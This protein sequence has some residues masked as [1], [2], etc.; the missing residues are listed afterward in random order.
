M[1][2]FEVDRIERGHDQE[3]GARPGRR[4]LRDLVLGDDEVLAEQRQG[5]G[6]RDITQVI[7]RAVEEGRLG[8][9]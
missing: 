3:H 5:H 9:D 7:Q 1:S 8:E 2:R 4:R 6:A